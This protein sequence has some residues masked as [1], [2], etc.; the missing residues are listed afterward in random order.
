MNHLTATGNHMPCG[1]TQCYLPPSSSDFP[2]LPG[3]SIQW[4][5]RDTW[6]SW[7]GWWLYPKIVYLPGIELASHKSD[8]Y[9]ISHQ[10][11]EPHTTISHVVIM[12][13]IGRCMLWSL[14]QMLTAIWR[15]GL[16]T[17]SLAFLSFL[18]DMTFQSRCRSLF[19][20]FFTTYT[21]C[22]LPFYICRFV[23]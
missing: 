23:R 17:I 18:R 1:I 4:S 11:P 13:C 6:L 7:P 19:V 12:Y 22:I 9:G 2:T 21:D 14:D 20:L 5:W 3:S 10:T 8:V 15:H 16:T